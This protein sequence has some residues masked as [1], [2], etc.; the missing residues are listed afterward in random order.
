MYC[1]YD[2]NQ[3]NNEYKREIKQGKKICTN[4]KI[5]AKIK[6]KLCNSKVHKDILHTY[7]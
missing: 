3:N 2:L 5:Y 1:A 7:K 4:H 6:R